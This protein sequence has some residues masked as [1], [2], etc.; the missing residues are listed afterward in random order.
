MLIVT[1]QSD[2]DIQFNIDS[3]Y[4]NWL[5]IN[6]CNINLIWSNDNRLK[7]HGRQT[8]KFNQTQF[9]PCTNYDKHK[10]YEDVIYSIAL[11]VY[12]IHINWIFMAMVS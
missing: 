12:C 3:T 8:I 1:S 6:S 4:G 7:S 10:K 9:D 11:G 5:D 2:V